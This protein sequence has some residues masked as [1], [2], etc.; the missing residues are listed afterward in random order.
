MKKIIIA[1]D[2]FKGSLSSEK[3][4]TIILNEINEFYPECEVDCIPM[5]DGGEGTVNCLTTAMNGELAQVLVNDPYYDKVSANIGL[6]RERNIGVIE[7]A[8][9]AGHSLVEGRKNP[10]LTTT[11]GVGELI[12]AA[13]EL[14]CKEIILGLGGACTNDA[15][16]GAASA[17]GV[18][19]YDKKG[20]IFV[21]TGGTLKKVDKI[22]ISNVNE[23]IK[24]VK[25]TTICDVDN[26]MFG[27]TGAAY[28]FAPQKGATDEMVQE[29]DEGLKWIAEAI[30]RDI[31]IDVSNIKGGGASGG[32]GAGMIAF[33]KSNLKK[34]IDTILDEVKFND[35]MKGSDL[36]I[37]GEGRVDQQSLG[38]KVIIGISERAKKLNV[39]VLVLAGGIEQC[40]EIYN[41]GISAVFPINRFPESYSVSKKYSEINV[42]NTIRDIFR[43]TKALGI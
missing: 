39:P 17:L 33:L 12:L 36:I 34:G 5:A 35:R 27:R 42:K 4:C 38:G 43:F 18:D 24:N 10:M 20:N 16:T 1:P 7:V 37:T 13:T 22:D 2:S 29:L 19:F 21:P 15:G 30:K 32:M 25:I 23:K 3:I 8:S 26:V 11:Y 6:I 40:E 14:G 9:C 41:H 28:V 31:G